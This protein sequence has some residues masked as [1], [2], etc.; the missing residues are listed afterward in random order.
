MSNQDIE[1]RDPSDH[2]AFVLWQVQHLLE[3]T[4]ERRL[5]G[6]GISLLQFAALSLLA[7]HPGSTSA[8]LARRLGLSPQAAHVMLTR[9]H[10]RGHVTRADAPSRGRSLPYTVT[11]RGR[12]TAR[13]AATTVDETE[14]EILAPLEP[15]E[16]RTVHDHLLRCLAEQR[17]DR[18]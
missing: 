13:L 5:E 10:A 17:G 6:L 11:D 9:L 14:R 12:E 3:Q 7:L 18:S 2:L 4:M 16:Q 1:T 8:D 15:G